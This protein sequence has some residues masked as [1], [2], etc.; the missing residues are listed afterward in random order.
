MRLYYKVLNFRMW[1]KLR[2]VR[3]MIFLYDLCLDIIIFE[4]VR[5][6]LEYLISLNSSCTLLLNYTRSQYCMNHLIYP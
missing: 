3:E 5:R 2:E 6:C 4:F 1:G